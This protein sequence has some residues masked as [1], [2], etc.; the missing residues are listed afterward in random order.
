MSPEDIPADSW[1][2]RLE[3]NVVEFDADPVEHD[4]DVHDRERLVGEVRWALVEYGPGAGR[5]GWCT[6]PHI[7][8]LIDGELEYVF[9]NGRPPMHLSAGNG[10]ALPELP[11]H[12]GRNHGS[13]PARL[14]IIDAL[15]PGA[16]Q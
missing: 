13:K 9:E 4:V 15:A 3:P 7:G 5:E 2:D 10:F 1:A 14:F 8:Y 16:R 6:E 11:G 12:A